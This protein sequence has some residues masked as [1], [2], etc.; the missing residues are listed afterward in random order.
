MYPLMWGV[1]CILRP[2]GMLQEN[3]RDTGGYHQ[4]GKDFSNAFIVGEH[5]NN[6][7]TKQDV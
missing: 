1:S 6:Q 3:H 2:R 7:A 4:K 5:V